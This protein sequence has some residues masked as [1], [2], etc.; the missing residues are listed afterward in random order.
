M[1][2]E[3]SAQRLAILI[4]EGRRF[5]STP[6]GQALRHAERACLG[7]ACERLFGAH[8]LELG[9]GGLLA[10]MCPVRHPLAWAPTRELAEGPS[11]LVCVPEAL[12]LPDDCLNLVVV[13]HLLEVAL[14]P[15][16]LLQEAAR[17]T[18]DGGR[19]IV[20]GWMPFSAGG[21]YRLSPARRQRLPWCGQ[22]RSPWRMRD[23]LAFVDFEIER[24]DY[25][26][27]HLPGT[28][29]RNALLETLGRRH[30]LAL[31]DSYMIQ[32][33]RRPQLAQHQGR[34]LRFSAP[35]GGPALGATRLEPGQAARYEK[36]K[37]EVE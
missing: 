20:F 36:R 5:W 25:C 29:P 22:W 23:W 32:A 10:D 13:H 37:R 34:R 14:D 28:P 24:V 21:L 3:T 31:G 19:L 9:F 15:H 7:P 27:F 1:S 26:G 30:N 2:T 16:H 17:V 4:R 33:C 12:P 18:A 8:S 35:L 6:E 11:T